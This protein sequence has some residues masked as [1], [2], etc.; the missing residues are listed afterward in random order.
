MRMRRLHRI[1]RAI[2]EL[3]KPV[4]AAVD[5]VCVGAGWS[6]ALAC[7]MVIASDRARFAQVF[8]NIALVPD[9]GAVWLLRRQIG[10]MRAK[11]MVYSGRM[12]GAEEALRLG[13]VLEVTAPDQLLARAQALA[14]SF[15]QGPTLALGMAKRQFDLAESASFAS[16]LDSEFAMQPTMSQTEDHR[17]GVTAFKEKRTACFTGE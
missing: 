16:F 10:A 1:A 6:Y 4:I 9:A 14:A 12:V 11:E 5:G 13:L 8:R 15:A 3:K 7:D 2:A 17:E